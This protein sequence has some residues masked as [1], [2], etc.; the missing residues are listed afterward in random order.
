MKGKV[1][2]LLFTLLVFCFSSQYTRNNENNNK[3]H[4]WTDASLWMLLV[5]SNQVMNSMEQCPREAGSDTD[6]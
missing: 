3:Y 2:L 6:F 4:Q 5:L 1:S